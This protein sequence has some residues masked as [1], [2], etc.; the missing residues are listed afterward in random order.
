MTDANGWPAP[1]RLGV[2]LNPDRVAYHWIKLSGGNLHAAL[3]NACEWNLGRDYLTPYEA[4]RAWRYIAPCLAPNEVAAAVAAEREACAALLE[5]M[6]RQHNAAMVGHWHSADTSLAY[7]D[8]ADAIR[9]RGT[10]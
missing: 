2:P 1:E 6:R 3:W 5:T 8:G 10:P 9:A 7:K 4:A